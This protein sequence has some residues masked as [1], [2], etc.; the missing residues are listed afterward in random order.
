[1]KQDWWENLNSKEAK[2]TAW[3][4]F[5][6]E[7]NQ[8]AMKIPSRLIILYFSYPLADFS[9]KQF[10]GFRQGQSHIYVNIIPG[11]Y[12]PLHTTQLRV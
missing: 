8:T 9:T 4:K 5:S 2:N 6:W 11:I 12:S 3:G 10:P 7:F 1:M